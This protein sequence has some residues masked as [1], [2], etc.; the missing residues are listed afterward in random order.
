[1]GHEALAAIS[2]ADRAGRL[3]L[4]LLS[5]PRAR[6]RPRRDFGASWRSI[7]S[8]SA[9]GKA[10]AGKCRRITATPSATSGA[11]RRRPAR[12][13][14]PPAASPGE[15]SSTANRTSSSRRSAT[16]RRA[17]AISIEA[18]CFAKERQL[19]VLFVVEDNAYGISSPTR[20]INPL[21]LD[22]LQPNDWRQID[23]ADV[24]AVYEAG[25]E[26]IAASPRGQGPGL[27]LGQDGAAFQPHE[28][29][30]SQALSQRGRNREPGGRRSAR[31]MEGA[32]I[33]EGVI[34]AE[35]YA[36][37]D[38]EIKERIRQEFIDGRTR[39]GSVGR[40]NWNSKSRASCRSSTTK[41]CPP[42]NTASATS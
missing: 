2:F 17:R 42:A 19:P 6:P 32:L 24:Q 30:R 38:Q 26:A 9:K 31:E 7:I 40:T 21:A 3:H 10:T 36:K 1:M 16:P 33:A 14:S 4:R 8:R 34:T 37:L 5:R 23:G 39:A 20:K 12:N 11:C 25:Q 13:S 18:V 35:D 15:S 41:S 29:G 22:V 27:F 28:L